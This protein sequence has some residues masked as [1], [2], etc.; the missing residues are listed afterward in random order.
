M[1]NKKNM[2]DECTTSNPHCDSVTCTVSV[3]YKKL[4]IYDEMRLCMF[5]AVEH[6]NDGSYNFEWC[7]EILERAK[8]MQ[9]VGK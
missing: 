6:L 8:K 3:I 4:K 1:S 2:C 9:E 5:W 7:K